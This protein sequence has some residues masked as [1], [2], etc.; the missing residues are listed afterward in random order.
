MNDKNIIK[1]NKASGD[2]AD[3]DFYLNLDIISNLDG[4]TSISVYLLTQNIDGEGATE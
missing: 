4:E 3:F 2:T 1:I